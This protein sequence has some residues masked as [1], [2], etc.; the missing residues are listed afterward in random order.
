MTSKLEPV[1]DMIDHV[2]GTVGLLMA[3]G[4]QSRTGIETLNSAVM[5]DTPRRNVG[6]Y[7]VS[8]KLTFKQ[9]DRVSFSP[10]DAIHS[11]LRDSF[12]MDAHPYL[13]QNAVNMVK[14]RKDPSGV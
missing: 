13:E 1:I 9:G 8:F 6:D 5:R 2:V 3:R 14:I 11:A 12:L 10:R 7:T 4:I